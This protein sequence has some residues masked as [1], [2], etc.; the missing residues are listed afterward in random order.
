MTGKLYILVWNNGKSQRTI[1]HSIK[2]DLPETSINKGQ[3]ELTK[4]YSMFAVFQGIR[5]GP[6]LTRS[7]Y[8]V[9]DGGV[10]PPAPRRRGH[11]HI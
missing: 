1:L 11:R 7:S 4:F 3:E 9:A 6:F 5:Q 10:E 8:G 2:C